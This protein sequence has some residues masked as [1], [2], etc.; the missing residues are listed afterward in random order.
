MLR[1]ITTLNDAQ[2][3]LRDLDDRVSK[4]FISNIDMKG[5][6][7]VNA[8]ASREAGDYVT[9]AEMESAFVDLNSRVENLRAE[10]ERIKI[11]LIAGGI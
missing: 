9:R 4:L 2:K 6:R 10:I 1:D 8:G 5:R 7:V 3:A 11:R